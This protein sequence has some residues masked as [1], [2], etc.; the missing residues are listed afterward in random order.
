MIK[1]PQSITN[2]SC[3]LNSF[4]SGVF[5]SKSNTFTWT[6][7]NLEIS[8]ILSLSLSLLNHNP[9]SIII[10]IEYKTKISISRLKISSVHCNN[11]SSVEKVF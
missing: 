3:I 8:S 2:V 6:I 10:K 7:G 1:F 9:T 5:D 4:G 11:I